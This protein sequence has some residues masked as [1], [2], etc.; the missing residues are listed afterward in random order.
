MFIL[1]NKP[2]STVKQFLK[3]T[4]LRLAGAEH[5]VQFNVPQVCKPELSAPTV[6]KVQNMLSGY[7]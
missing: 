7:R 3:T 5:E 2:I 6:Y 4:K 1:N